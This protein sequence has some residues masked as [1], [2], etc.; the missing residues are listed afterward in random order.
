MAFAGRV[1]AAASLRGGNLAGDAPTS[2]RLL[3]S[4]IQADVCVAGADNDCSY[5]PEMAKRLELALR[6][7]GLHASL[8]NLPRRRTRLDDAGFPGVR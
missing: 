6:H 5:P 4:R 7:A 2:P 3:A 8:R 1:L